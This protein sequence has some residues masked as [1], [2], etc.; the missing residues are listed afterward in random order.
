MKNR[1]PKTSSPAD[2]FPQLLSAL[3]DGQGRVRV[4][5]LHGM[6]AHD[7]QRTL[8]ALTQQAASQEPLLRRAAFEGLRLAAD[9]SLG[10]DFH[11]DYV[12][13]CLA[14][15]EAASGDADPQVRK[16]ALTAFLL[17]APLSSKVVQACVN[18]LNEEDPGIVDVS[19]RLLG[20]MGPTAPASARAG[21]LALLQGQHRQEALTTLDAM[22]Q[23]AVEAVGDLLRLQNE[24]PQDHTSGDP[25]GSFERLLVCLAD[26]CPKVREGAAWALASFAERTVTELVLQ[27]RLDCLQVLADSARRSDFLPILKRLALPLARREVG[28]KRAIQ[29]LAAL[30]LLISLE[31]QDADLYIQALSDKKEF[32]VEAAVRALERLG[33]R[34]A[35]AV[36]RLMELLDGAHQLGATRALGAIGGASAR[37]LPKLRRSLQGATQ[38]ARTEAEEAIRLIVEGMENQQEPTDMT[39]V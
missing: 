14:L 17:G 31:C 10:A 13:D 26:G 24:D 36:P 5:A 22:G 6:V 9:P 12:R 21:V 33:P 23:T 29:R 8:Q 37:A 39:I 7:P 20:K 30:S 34:A 4:D 27:G 28:H 11:A 25:T 3:G 35:M 2:P 32:V 1:R 16:Q 19:L 18:G 38:A 15:M